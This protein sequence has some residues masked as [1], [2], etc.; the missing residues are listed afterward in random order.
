[1]SRKLMMFN[2]SNTYVVAYSLSGA[3]K[4]IRDRFE[5]TRGSK[6]SPVTGKIPYCDEDGKE[7]GK[8][9]ATD[10][11]GVWPFPMIIPES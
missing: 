3:A 5:T 11:G 6:V 10:C 9:D 7:L 2:W 8:V 4:L 1:M